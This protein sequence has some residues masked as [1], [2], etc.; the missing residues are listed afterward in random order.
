MKTLSEI[1]QSVARY[2]EAYSEIQSIQEESPLIPEGDQKTGCIGELYGYLYLAN[3]NPG[4]TLTYG[5]HSEK[6]WDIECET[7]G[8][9]KRIQIKT[10]SAYSKTRTIS[11]IH[12]GWD[13][14]F[15]IYVDRNLAPTGFWIIA[16]TA[17]V[18]DGAVRKGCKC[19]DPDK[20]GTGSPTLP[21]GDNR[22]AEMRTAIVAQENQSS[23][24]IA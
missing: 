15:I 22:I 2:A 11:P 21:F 5:S 14:L 24:T 23:V 16:D 4:A 3:A 13:E 12:H 19:R 8:R 17:I 18:A 10:V 9:S 20:V 7:E 1:L 6:G